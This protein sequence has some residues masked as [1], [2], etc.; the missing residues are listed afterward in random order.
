MEKL[1]ATAKPIDITELKEETKISIVDK[2]PKSISAYDLLG[3][4]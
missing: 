4:E 1:L 2:T 3:M